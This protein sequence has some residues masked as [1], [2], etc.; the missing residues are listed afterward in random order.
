MND[1]LIIG[2]GPVGLTIAAELARHRVRCRIV[3]R[4]AQP[5]PYCRAIGVTPRTLEI[6]DDMGIARSMMD[7]GLCLRGMR[8]IRYGAPPLDFGIDL[9]DLPY[10]QLGIPQY[11]TERILT[12]HLAGFGI[13]IERPVTAVSVS[14]GPGAVQVELQLA[15]GGREDA[16]FRYVVGCDGAGS[17]VRRSLGIPFEGDHFPMEFM[18]GDVLMDCGLPPGFTLRAVRPIQDDAPDFFV[19]IPLPER[20]RYRVSMLA[21]TKLS[22]RAGPAAGHGLQLE[23]QA[24]SLADLQEVA[25]RLLPE[26]VQLSDYALVIHIPDWYAA[27]RKLQGG[28]RIY[29]RRC[30]AHS[31]A[32]RRTG[33]EHGNP[34]RL[35][36]GLENGIGTAW[37]SYAGIAR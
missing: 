17:T 35:Q 24:P 22:D 21:P 11:E 14:N 19:A 2:A 13:E 27:G 25:D 16:E 32:H 31:P 36:S 26:K 12:D 6:W 4:L 18:L 7:A 15:D 8:L 5:L 9:H 10:G 1:V 29:C 28:K 20:N 30:R 3:D 34:G 37:A 33:H 23:R